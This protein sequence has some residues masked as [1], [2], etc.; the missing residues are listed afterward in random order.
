MKKL[1]LFIIGLVIIFFLPRVI[2]GFSSE[3]DFIFDFDT[4]EQKDFGI[5][6][7]AHVLETGEPTQL[8]QGRLE[9]GA[10][11]WRAG[12]VK[13]LVV[14]NTEEAALIM[15]DYLYELD[16]P[17]SHVII[18]RTAQITTDSCNLEIHPEYK[19]ASV[20]YIS[21][22]FHLPRTLFQCAKL[23][24][25]GSGYPAELSDSIDRSNTLI[26][27]KITIRS[28]RYLRES[29]LTWLSILNLYPTNTIDFHKRLYD[30]SHLDLNKG[31]ITMFYDDN[32]DIDKYSFLIN[33]GMFHSDFSS[34]GLFIEDGIKRAPLNIDSGKGNFFMDPNGVFYISDIGAAVI[35]TTDYNDINEDVQFATQSGPMLLVNGKINS[36]FV[37][38]S[39]NLFIRNGVCALTLNDVYFV[40][41]NEPV[42]FYDFAGQFKKLGCQNA[43][44]LDGFVSKMF[45]PQI[46]RYDFEGEFG[47]IIGYKE[48]NQVR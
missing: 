45:A 1:L 23:G 12:I 22:K 28:K 2:L 16:I 46:G 26:L 17:R 7:G 36:G 10:K 4:V 41:S 35:S 47:V 44:Y 48:I 11:L 6:L 33:A 19:N 14:S 38:G 39:E 37:K 30:I 25:A 9:A 18:D 3:S 29:A 40:I 24:L 20:V 43:L 42:N 27:T 31:V 34:V 13:R 21:Q 8:L 32:R 15:A 5:I